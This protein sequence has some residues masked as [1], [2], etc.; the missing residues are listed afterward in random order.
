MDTRTTILY[1]V[2]AILLMLLLHTRMRLHEA[3]W[4]LE[5]AVELG[6]AA[7][8]YMQDELKEPRSVQ[9]IHNW[10]LKKLEEEKENGHKA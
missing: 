9:F 2:I 3:N 8:Q 5:R 1:W 4:K 7:F 6:A 10:M